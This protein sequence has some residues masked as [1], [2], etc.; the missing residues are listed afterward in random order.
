MLKKPLWQTV[1]TDAVCFYTLKLVSNVWQLFAADDLSRRHF[2]MHFFSW[3]LRVKS[4][5]TNNSEVHVVVFKSDDTSVCSLIRRRQ[6]NHCQVISTNQGIF[7]CRPKNVAVERQSVVC[8]RTILFLQD[9]VSL[10]TLHTK[11]LHNP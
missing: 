1:W 8:G 6:L 4:I 9:K 5:L 11:R 10:V 7:G 2:Q 3:H